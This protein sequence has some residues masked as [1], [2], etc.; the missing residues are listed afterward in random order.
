MLM[1]NGRTDQ[2]TYLTGLQNEKQKK[3]VSLNIANMSTV[4]MKK[5]SVF[6]QGQLKMSLLITNG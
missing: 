5:F 6:F 3:V 2:K 4:S 1:C